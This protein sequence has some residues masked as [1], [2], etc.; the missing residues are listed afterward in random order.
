MT[1]NLPDDVK[2]WLQFGHPLLMWVLFGL[3]LYAMYLGLQVRRT[4]SAEGEDKKALIQGQFNQKHHKI[5][6]LLLAM[7]VLGNIG[8]MAVT[9]LNNEKLFVGPHLLAGLAMTGLIALSASLTPF[10]QKGQDWAR[11]GHILA[12]VAIVG[13]FG[14]QAFTGVEIVQKILTN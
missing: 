14:W 1:F 6:S 12:N 3:T 5:G 13:L 4:R 8:G 7:M 11:N 9:Y 10:M 2:Y